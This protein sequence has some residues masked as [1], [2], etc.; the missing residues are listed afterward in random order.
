MNLDIY[1][2]VTCPV[3]AFVYYALECIRVGART[4]YSKD[5]SLSL[6]KCVLCLWFLAATFTVYER[7]KHTY[8]QNGYV[9]YMRKL[10]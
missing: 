8:A 4:Y 1:M 3:K 10:L 5:F 2:Y 7:F 9:Y 6:T